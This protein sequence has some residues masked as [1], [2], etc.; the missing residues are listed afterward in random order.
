[1]KI[2]IQVLSLFS[3]SKALTFEI[4]PKKDGSA[5]AINIFYPLRS[6]KNAL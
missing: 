4:V 2:L 6:R 3:A 1:M 5:Q